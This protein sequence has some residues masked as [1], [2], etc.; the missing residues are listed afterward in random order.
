MF[1]TRSTVNYAPVPGRT[2]HEYDVVPASQLRTALSTDAATGLA[3]E[4]FDNPRLEGNPVLRIFQDAQEVQN[5][6]H[7]RRPVKIFFIFH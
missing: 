3:A 2:I 5:I 6:R 4:Y 1:T 7:L